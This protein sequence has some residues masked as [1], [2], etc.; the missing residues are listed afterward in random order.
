MNAN[1]SCMVDF[2]FWILD[3]FCFEHYLGSWPFLKE[4]KK[5]KK[6]DPDS[7]MLKLHSSLKWVQNIQNIYHK[8]W[9]PQGPKT[10]WNKNRTF[11]F[12][13]FVW[14]FN[15]LQGVPQI[16]MYHIFYNCHIILLIY[17]PFQQPRWNLVQDFSYYLR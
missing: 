4:V 9:G 3:D 10:D 2:P 13:I 11:E 17:Y 1:W 15:H 16:F 5:I 12:R 6:N 8:Y 7:I 14:N